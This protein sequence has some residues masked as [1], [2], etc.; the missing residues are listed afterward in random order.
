MTLAE[1]KAAVRDELGVPSTDTRRLPPT[2]ITS[3]ANEVCESLATRRNWPFL[4]A[5][6]PTTTLTGGQW[7]PALPADFCRPFQVFVQATDGTDPYEPD[8]AVYEELLQ[9]YPVP[10][11]AATWGAP[12]YA[13]LAGSTLALGPPPLAGTKLTVHYYKFPAALVGDSDT[14]EMAT[15]L[16]RAVK[17]LTVAECADYDRQADVAAAARD[18]G[19]RAFREVLYNLNDAARLNQQPEI[20]EPE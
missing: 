1:I 16:G 4:L 19:E 6:A 15:T 2:K 20:S 7:N 5:V 8:A 14:N 3:A 11:D 18:K 17:W 12:R 10:T 13:A 9:R